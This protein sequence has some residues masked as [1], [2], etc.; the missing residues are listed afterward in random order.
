MNFE[1]YVS[2]RRGIF[3]IVGA[4]EQHV[5]FWLT[6]IENVKETNMRGHGIV[7]MPSIQY[8]ETRS[9][10][11]FNS[12]SSWSSLSSI[13]GALTPGAFA[14]AGAG[15]STGGAAFAAS[16]PFTIVIFRALIISHNVIGNVITKLGYVT[17][18]SGHF[19]YA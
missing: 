1:Y 3:E 15:F 7:S 2:S 18:F 9:S 11:C 5:A 17:L 19:R 12:L 16:F 4:S 13:G 8:L 10:C 6:Q 14:T